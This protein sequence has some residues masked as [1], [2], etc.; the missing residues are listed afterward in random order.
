MNFAYVVKG[1][2]IIKINSNGFVN[3]NLTN[4]NLSFF[5]NSFVEVDYF[6]KTIVVLQ[7]YDRLSISTFP[8][9]IRKPFKVSSHVN[10][11]R[12]V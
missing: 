2:D 9:V 8:N 7:N 10:Y 12:K 4:K 5:F 3:Q 1:G 11:L 6:L